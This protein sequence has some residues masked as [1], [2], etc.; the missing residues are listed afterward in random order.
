[1]PIGA[2]FRL[3]TG[4]V[5]TPSA[6]PAGAFPPCAPGCRVEAASCQTER[7]ASQV[8]ARCPH[9]LVLLSARHS[10]CL[11]SPEGLVPSPRLGCPQPLS[12][13]S[14]ADGPHTGASWL[15]F[16]CRLSTLLNVTIYVQY[17]GSYIRDPSCRPFREAAACR[18]REE[19]RFA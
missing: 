10:P 9:V 16:P 19:E 15:R 7:V 2:V 6:V 1:M 14:E 13:L 4:S 3:S 12:R 11:L 17:G 8:A 5:R 18:W